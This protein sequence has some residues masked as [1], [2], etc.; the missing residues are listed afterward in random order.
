LTAAT[1]KPASASTHGGDEWE[2][3]EAVV[4]T[5]PPPS[6]EDGPS[7]EELEAQMPAD[8]SSGGATIAHG[9]RPSRPTRGA[10]KAAVEEDEPAAVAMPELDA[11][12]ERLPNDVRDTLDELFRARFVTVKRVPVAALQARVAKSAEDAV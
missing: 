3:G 12:V 6:S 11:L 4:A 7:L 1:P 9:D 5:E 10:G 2:Q 8:I